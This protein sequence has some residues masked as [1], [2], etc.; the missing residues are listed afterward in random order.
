MRWA[1][2]ALLLVSQLQPSLQQECGNSDV[3]S[4]AAYGD[5]SHDDTDAFLRQE[6]DG[7]AGVIY[8][9]PGN[10]RIARSITLTKPIIASQD[11]TFQVRH[12]RRTR[13]VYA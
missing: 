6:N 9:S 4:K 10:Y 11:A 13:P 5:G 1:A 3:R 8:M 7:G 12:V 2:L